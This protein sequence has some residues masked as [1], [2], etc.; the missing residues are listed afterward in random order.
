MRVPPPRSTGEDSRAHRR[1]SEPTGR[2][3]RRGRGSCAEFG[4]LLP[5]VAEDHAVDHTGLERRPVE[6]RRRQHVQGVEPAARLADVLDD[7]VAGNGSRTTPGSRTDSAPGRRASTRTRTSSRARPRPAASSSGRWDRRGWAASSSS[8]AG[9]CRSVG[10]HA[11][12]AL[13]LVERAVHVDARVGG[14]VA[15]PHR[16]RGAPEPVAGDR[17]VPGALEPLAERAV[18][19]VVGDPGDLLVVGRGAGP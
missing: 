13:E 18:L 2:R 19:D 14:V 9:R 3:P 10:R 6:Q 7:E 1:A 17:P 16:D 12:V 8:I 11:E 4:C 15:L 5:V